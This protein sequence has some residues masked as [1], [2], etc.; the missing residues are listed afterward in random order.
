[1]KISLFIIGAT[2]LL[3]CQSSDSPMARIPGIAMSD[4]GRY[5]E[6]QGSRGLVV[7]RESPV[8]DV[9][10]PIGFVLIDSRSRN[11]TTSNHRFIEHFYQGRAQRKDL[12]DFYRR[13]T[14]RRGWQPQREQTAG[15][16]TWIIFTRDDEDLQVRISYRDDIAEVFVRVRS[17]HAVGAPTPPAIQAVKSSS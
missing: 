1:M 15:A 5:L 13:S 12:L 8:R 17:H 6:P 3:S 7:S 9:P 14:N 4:D 10:M 11:L 16:A 2:G